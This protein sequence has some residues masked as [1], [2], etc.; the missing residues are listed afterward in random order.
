VTEAASDYRTLIKSK[1]YIDLPGESPKSK[2]WPGVNNLII[3]RKHRDVVFDIKLGTGAAYTITTDRPQSEYGRFYDPKRNLNVTKATFKDGEPCHIWVGRTFEG[4]LILKQG[5]KV[6]GRY[7]IRKMDCTQGCTEDPKDKPAP[8]LIVLHDDKTFAKDLLALSEVPEIAQQPVSPKLS[9]ALNQALASQSSHQG[10]IVPSVAAAPT[11]FS[12]A[13]ANASAEALPTIH[14]FKIKQTH[15]P[16]VPEWNCSNSL[17]A[18]MKSSSGTHL[19]RFRA[20][21]SLRRLAVQLDL[22][23]MRSGRTGRSE[24]FGIAHS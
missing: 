13:H 21:S 9:S 17:R 20:T 10:G 22:A 1:H 5:E 8:V 11:P 6:L 23:G 3:L 4:C 24:S 14:A 2:L 7:P 16:D 15:G 19:I 12:D 18:A